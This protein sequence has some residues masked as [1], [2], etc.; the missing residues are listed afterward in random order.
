MPRVQPL[1]QKSLAQQVRL[2]SQAAADMR[3]RQAQTARAGLQVLEAPTEVPALQSAHSVGVQV[4]AAQWLALA[5]PPDTV[6][7]EAATSQASVPFW[8]RP[9]VRQ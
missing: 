5:E 4:A 2:Q 1:W 6:A 9:E 3:A 8:F 7:R